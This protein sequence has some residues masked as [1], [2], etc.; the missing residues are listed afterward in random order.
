MKEPKS[1]L[2]LNEAQA[3]Y[4]L[5][6]PAP[7]AAGWNLDDRTQ[8]GYEIPVDGYD[9]APWNGVTDYCLY[10]PAGEAI[11]VVEAK[12]CSRNP[13]VVDTE[14]RIIQPRKIYR[15]E[16]HMHRDIP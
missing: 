12:R 10:A 13:R 1:T 14:L 15:I 5:I 2:S 16:R 3:R 6:D 8:V 11:A 9:A 4:L 7:K